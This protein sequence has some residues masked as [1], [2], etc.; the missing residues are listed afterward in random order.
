MSE[1]M[2]DKE[3][4]FRTNGNYKVLFGEETRDDSCLK[5][6]T[7]PRVNRAG[8]VYP[9]TGTNSKEKHALLSYAVPGT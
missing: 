3:N 7:N 2:G 4:K 8:F 5:M 6:R 9:L 1:I